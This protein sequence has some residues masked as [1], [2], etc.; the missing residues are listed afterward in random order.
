M[1]THW[2]HTE[3]LFRTGLT[4]RI[5]LSFCFECGRDM[6]VVGYI[7]CYLMQPVTSHNF[8]NSMVLHCPAQPA[9]RVAFLRTAHWRIGQMTDS[10]TL[11]FVC[12]FLLYDISVKQYNRSAYYTRLTDNLKIHGDLL[13]NIFVLAEFYW[14]TTAP[15]LSRH[16]SAKIISYS[17]VS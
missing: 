15:Q 1:N 8:E 6:Q 3:N 14:G 4:T 12:I 13:Q 11:L 2:R 5:P 10:L 7:H 9:R 17:G 16:I